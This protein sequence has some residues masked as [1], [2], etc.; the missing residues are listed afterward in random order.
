M[1]RSHLTAWKT[2]KL[3]KIR[4]P[5][6]ATVTQLRQLIRHAVGFDRRTVKKYQRLMRE[7]GY[8]FCNK[9]GRWETSEYIEELKPKSLNEILAS[10]EEF[11]KHMQKLQQKVSNLESAQS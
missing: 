7:M 1:N 11:Q 10:E 9:N 5:N 2:A 6:G 8:V 3:L 4:H